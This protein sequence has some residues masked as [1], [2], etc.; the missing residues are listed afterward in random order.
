[1]FPRWRHAL[2]AV[3]WLATLHPVAAAPA[4]PGT[5]PLV[6]RG[7]LSSNMVAGIS[8]FLDRE[9]EA[10]VA[11]RVAHWKRD[12][13]SP[14]YYARSVAPQRERL[15]VL[16]GAVDARAAGGE[17]ELVGGVRTPST[18]AETA[19][20]SIRAV[21]WPVLAGVHGE[22]LLLEPKGAV[23]ASVIALADATQTP[24][25]LCGLAPGLAPE[26]Q[27]ARRLAE[28]G[29]RVLVPVMVN[30]DDTFSGNAARNRW[31]N[32]PHREWLWRMAWEL[33]RTPA[34]YEVQKILAA[35]DLLQSHHPEPGAARPP[36][37]LIGY[38]E[39]GLLA[40]YAAALDQ[41]FRATV[42]SGAFEPLEQLWRQPQD[43]N[44]WNLL[45]EFGAAEIASLVAPRALLVE[46]SRPVEITG[47]PPARAGRRAVAAPGTVT[48][49]EF[50]AVETEVERARALAGT[51]GES[52]RFRYGAEGTPVGPGSN[53]TLTEL[54]AALG[55]RLASLQPPGP[56]PVDA[57]ESFDPV[58]RQR[59]TVREIEDHLQHLLQACELTRNA[60]FWNR[61]RATNAAAW[62]A[63]LPELR[64]RLENEVIGAFPKPTLPLN[65]RSRPAL[66]T[67]GAPFVSP[68]A[69][70]TAHD[71]TLDVFPDVFAWGVL[72]LPNDLKP[73]ER[74]PVVVC[75]HGLEGLPE[76]CLADDPSTRA[77]AA[78]RA[79]AARLAER[80][81][82]VF[83]PHNPYRGGDH[84][85]VLQRKANLLGKTL[86]S[87]INAQHARILDWLEAQPFTDPKRIAFYGLSYGGKTAMRTPAVDTRYCLSICSGD[88][89]EWVRKNAAVDYPS[90]Y[91][92]TP[93]YEI[94]E[95]NLGHTFNYAE[96][97]A[98][99]APRP[100]MVE[101]GHLDGVGVDEWVNYEYAKVRRFYTQL[102]LAD[103]TE[104]EHFWGPHTIHGVG[105]FDFLHRHLRWPKR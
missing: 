80:G 44:V 59:R 1:M 42:V 5:Q 81:F 27:F 13:S 4:L 22:G 68:S 100:F 54:L 53:R 97:A 104:I 40:L 93:E 86:F 15:R 73:G 63:Q 14:E 56:A 55:H 95:W 99:I 17:F 79:F 69:T 88:F 64:A 29:C 103:R 75:Q 45:T 74:R 25:Q 39:G 32:L 34:G 70:F 62:E 72:L 30:R 10:S 52:L 60:N 57:R 49:P 101:R 77:F 102:G 31:T 82:V 92:Y 35:A 87:V 20:Y 33:G 61:I 76:H 48:T 12:F 36:L 18:V 65:P 51:L 89:N 3:G 66:G 16:L 9:I 38:G 50:G 6:A 96:M 2:L 83:V 58:E 7:D 11:K 67:N 47:P 78:Y 90:S 98:L 19:R 21:R 91:L 94:F 71:V 85:R 8:R 84:F 41:R 23:V 43:R 28:H 105:T 46:Y 37:G 24:E 26:N